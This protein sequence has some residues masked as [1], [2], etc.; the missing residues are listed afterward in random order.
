MFYRF[1]GFSHSDALKSPQKRNQGLKEVL[2]FSALFP[3][4]PQEL[5]AEKGKSQNNNNKTKIL[6]LPLFRIFSLAR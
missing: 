4:L 6:S 2:F 5:L 3:C 1:E